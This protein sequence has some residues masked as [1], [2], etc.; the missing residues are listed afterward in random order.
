V[1]SLRIARRYAKALLAIGREDGQ[2]ET[3]KG[4]L[5]GFVKLLDEHKELEMAIS[6]PLYDDEG[7]KRVLEMVVQRSEVSQVMK[8]FLSLLFEKGRIQYLRDIN[9]FYEK[10]TD[11]LANIVRAD[12]VSATDVSDETIERIRSALAQKTGKD[13]KMDV[14][15]DPTLIGGA[16]TKIG[17]LVLDGSVRTQLKSLKESLQRS[18]VI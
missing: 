8:S 10:L 15:V 14:S 7:R 16:V 4:E 12:L 13:V 18:E 2:A 9:A 5:E 3:Y 1:I 6:N 17:D 11:E